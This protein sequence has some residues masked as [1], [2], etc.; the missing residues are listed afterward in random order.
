MRVEV[1]STRVRSAALALGVA[2]AAVALGGAC[3]GNKPVAKTSTKVEEAASCPVGDVE[4][5]TAQLAEGETALTASGPDG[6]TIP[7]RRLTEVAKPTFERDALLPPEQ[8]GASRFEVL[9]CLAL[10]TRTEAGDERYPPD[11]PQES[12]IPKKVDVRIT[13]VFGGAIVLHELSHA[14]CLRAGVESKLEGTTLTLTER[15]HGTAC[16]CRCSSSIRTAVGVQPGKYTLVLNVDEAG[17]TREAA[18]TEFTVE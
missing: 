9:G 13:P 5:L 18:R 4:A 15:L 17:Q 16:R 10:K 14:C 6:G 2:L 11:L 7:A 1:E 3:A 8:P 12:G